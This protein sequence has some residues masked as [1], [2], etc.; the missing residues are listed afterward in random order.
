MLIS[1]SSVIQKLYF[2]LEKRKKIM[3]ESLKTNIL[4]DS[5]NRGVI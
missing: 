1:D 3:G 4:L 2:A 5:N